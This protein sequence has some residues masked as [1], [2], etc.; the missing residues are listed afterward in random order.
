MRF[1][2]GL[3]F[4]IGRIADGK[5]KARGLGGVLGLEYRQRCVIGGLTKSKFCL[6]VL[7]RVSLNNLEK[8]QIQEDGAIDGGEARRNVGGEVGKEKR[9]EDKRLGRKE[10]GEL[11]KRRQKWTSGKL[12]TKSGAM[13]EQKLNNGISTITIGSQKHNVSH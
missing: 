11:R 5:H 10:V 7:K 6:A 3:E 9:L 12:L 1:A 13:S 4:Y 8:E 2:G